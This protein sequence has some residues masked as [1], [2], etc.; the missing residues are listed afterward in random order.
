MAAYLFSLQCQYVTREN[1]LILCEANK[2]QFRKLHI[3][4]FY[5]GVIPDDVRGFLM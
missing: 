3:G 5:Q 2:K 1:Y 4:L